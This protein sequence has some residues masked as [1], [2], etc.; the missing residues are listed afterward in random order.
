MA[1]S[2]ST[3][4]QSNEKIKA[5]STTGANLGTALLIAGFG[6]VWLGGLE[7]WPI[8]WIAF[9]FALMAFATHLPNYL[10]EE[11]R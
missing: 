10:R 11:D 5:W 7:P 8:A 9:G 2:T 3:I 4:L 6:S 1:W